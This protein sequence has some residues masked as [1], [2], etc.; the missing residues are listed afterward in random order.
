MIGAA[1]FGS[2]VPRHVAA[3]MAALARRGFGAVLHPVGEH[4]LAWYRGTLPALFAASRDAGLVVAASPLTLGN[5]FGGEGESRFVVEHPETWQVLDS[6][7]AVPAACPNH[8]RT[9]A[10]LREFAEVVVAAGA[11]RVL[12]EEPRW[13]E[14][15]R[16][17]RAGAGAWACRC[18]ACRA[19][20]RE[21]HGGE[22]P[23]AMSDELA[24]FRAVCVHELLE[25]L[26][27]CTARLGAAPAVCAPPDDPE[28]W[29]ALAALP[30][31]DAL[32]A[33]PYW[34]AL[35]LPVDPCVG[36]AA[37]RVAAVAGDHG[38]RSQLWLQAFLLE[39][40]D[41]PDLARAV[42]LAR[43]TGVSE[44]WAWGFEA[45]AAM[46]AMACAQPERL[47]DALCAALA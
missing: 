25:E 46:S 33:T 22:L 20:F 8:P 29:D 28:A 47:W 39:A 26:V 14:P 11:Q 15:A 31:L 27:A 9:R 30:G 18:D 45:C 23:A 12:W 24:A 16:F 10:W 36:E 7:H 3:D 1:Y 6:G 21:R 5:L 19:R 38:V 13:A 44:L 41:A 32:A 37:R 42:A 34:K 17:G 43:A 40:D 2:R 35:G 4:D